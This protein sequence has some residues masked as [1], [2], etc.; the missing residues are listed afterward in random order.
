[1]PG[2][3]PHRAPYPNTWLD[4][5]LIDRLAQVGVTVALESTATLSEAHR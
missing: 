1:M 5:R 4:T 3:G 2:V